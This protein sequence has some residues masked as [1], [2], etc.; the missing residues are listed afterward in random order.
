MK[1]WLQIVR[2]GRTGK[3]PA[4]KAK[5]GN[6]RKRKTSSLS[7]LSYSCVRN[8]GYIWN[9]KKNQRHNNWV[10]ACANGIFLSWLRALTCSDW[11]LL[12]LAGIVWPHLRGWSDKDGKWR[13]YILLQEKG[14][15]SGTIRDKGE[16]KR[17]GLTGS[18]QAV[19][20]DEAG[21]RMC[22]SACYVERIGYGIL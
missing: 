20:R 4:K 8:V 21:C 7:R 12:S 11:G 16:E 1:R 17:S 10:Y 13:A 22:Y 14:W 5:G 2:L 9:W 19:Y 6:L 3:Q 15:G 18:H